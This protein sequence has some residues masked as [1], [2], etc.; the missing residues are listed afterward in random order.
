MVVHELAH[1]P[2]HGSGHGKPWH[3]LISYPG[4]PE[5]RVR[6]G[7]EIRD[8]P[9]FVGKTVNWLVPLARSR[10]AGRLAARLCIHPCTDNLRSGVCCVF[11]FFAFESSSLESAIHPAQAIQ[12][13]CQQLESGIQMAI[14][15]NSMARLNQSWVLVA[16]GLKLCTIRLSP[17]N[18][19]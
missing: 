8:S 16:I 18:H 19:E 17:Q 10:R 9:G 12:I 1:G 13:S 11:F 3:S 4:L 5:N 14:T 7:Y 15:F 6:S 2:V